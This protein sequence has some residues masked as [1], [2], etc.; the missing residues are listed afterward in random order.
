[1]WDFFEVIL[2]PFDRRPS[3]TL[4]PALRST[5]RHGDSSYWPSDNN[6]ID[7]SSLNGRC[8]SELWSRTFLEA[9]SDV[10]GLPERRGEER[11]GEERKVCCL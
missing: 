2:V 7:R 11:R 3:G 9:S 4:T 5:G 1:M 8:P 6:L 10:T